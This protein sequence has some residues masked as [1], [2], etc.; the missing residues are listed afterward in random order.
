MTPRQQQIA[1]NVIRGVA[2]ALVAVRVLAQ[3]AVAYIGWQRAAL[4]ELRAKAAE[5][6]TLVPQRAAH[7]DAL[8]RAQD[9]SQSLEA[10]VRDQSV[11]RILE[12]L[13]HEAK[14]HY[15]EL[16]VVQESAPDAERVVRFGPH[17]A[18]REVPLRLHLRG[19]YRQV[20]EFLGALR[21]APFLAAVRE[22]E[23]VKSAEQFGQLTTDLQLVVYLA[24]KHA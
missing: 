14:A 7:E 20:G 22:A 11:A 24:D 18:L 4:G 6:A 12:T 9:R 1:L 10:R 19:R 2:V 13:S 15:L 3:P 23:I 17:L 5:A 16:T 21:A 8:Q